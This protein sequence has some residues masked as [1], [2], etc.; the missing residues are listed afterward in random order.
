MLEVDIK[1]SMRNSPNLGPAWPAWGGSWRETLA[2]AQPGPAGPPG[3]AASAFDAD[4]PEAERTGTEVG[5][6]LI[7][8]FRLARECLAQALQ[9]RCPRFKII[10]MDFDPSRIPEMR[11]WAD[12][13]LLCMNGGEA[14]S[15][16][17]Q[18]ALQALGPSAPPTLL[19]SNSSSEREALVALRTGAA[20]VFSTE[21]GLHLLVA[22]IE[23]LLAGGRYVP[24]RLLSRWCEP[25]GA[26]NPAPDP[27]A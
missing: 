17:A 27:G 16:E 8:H 23:V 19:I 5:I 10:D 2:A 18:A 15:G 25:E 20:G 21:E 14:P 7:G 9:R 22:A 24:S 1:S 12:V 11:T 3:A 13:V 6:L 4:H 26:R